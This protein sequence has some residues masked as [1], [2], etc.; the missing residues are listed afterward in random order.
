M[1]QKSGKDE[2]VDQQ[3]KIYVTKDERIELVAM[4]EIVGM[5]FSSFARAVLL[6]YE[7]EENPEELRKI[8]YEVNK[9]GVNVN[10]MTKVANQKGALPTTQELSNLKHQIVTV[11]EEL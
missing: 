4:A 7:V 1:I 8:R 9:I 3:M 11:L 6:E 10:Q 5:S 2:K